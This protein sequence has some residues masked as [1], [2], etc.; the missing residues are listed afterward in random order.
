MKKFYSVIGIAISRFPMT[1][2]FPQQCART[3]NWLPAQWLLMWLEAVES[4]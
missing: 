4:S 1:I 2:G 3:L